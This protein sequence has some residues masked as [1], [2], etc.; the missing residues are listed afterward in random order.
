MAVS[1]TVARLGGTVIVVWHLGLERWIN[2]ASREQLINRRDRRAREIARYACETVPYYRDLVRR[3]AIDIRK[4]RDACDLERLPL[5][6]KPAVQ[7][8]PEAFR[9]E[10]RAGRDAIPFRTTGSTG[11]PLTVFHDRRSLLANIAYSERERAVEAR[12]IGRL[13]SYPVLDV[14]APAG[15]V[16]RVQA[17]YAQSTFRPLRPRR[18]AIGVDNPVEEVLAAVDRLRP[19]II[20]S[21]G[22]YLE[23]LFRAAAASRSLRHRPAAVMYSGDTMSAAGRDFIERE[24][25][26]PVLSAYDAVES[27]KIGFTCEERAGFHLHEDLCHV[28][29]A[30][31]D[32]H[33]V[34][35]GET[36][37]VVLSNLVNRGTVLLNYRL[38]DLA[39]LTSEPCR[40]GRPTRR[41]LDLAGRVDEIVLLDDGSF[42]YPTEIWRVVRERPGI[43][44]YQLVQQ[45]PARFQFRAVGDGSEAAA[46][47]IADVVSALRE[48]LRGATIEPVWVSELPGGPGGKFQLVV[49]LTRSLTR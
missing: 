45:A 3:V 6:N 35:E 38:G 13:Y 11:L 8:D 28:W 32:G 29:L 23:L 40:C 34:A 37:E 2:R 21:Y 48:P 26:I 49:P 30:G 15:T 42:V 41:L 43:I 4:L 39:R 33:P 1:D 27:F 7:A 20:R 44:R 5:L 12:F 16:N 9:S 25:G 14:R 46:R 31:S 47:S 24:F 19:A 22:G 36:G 18:Q 10:S 17:V